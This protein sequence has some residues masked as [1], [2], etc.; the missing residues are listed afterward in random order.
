MIRFVAPLAAFFTLVVAAGC[1]RSGEFDAL[2]ALDNRFDILISGGQ[3]ADG[4]GAAAVRADVLVR[5]DT[6]AY[7]GPVDE[8]RV[9]VATSIDA[10]GRIV[11]PGFID[12]HAHGNPIRDP[13]LR[14]FLAMGVTTITLGQDGSS[15]R[16][17]DLGAWM[18]S[19]DA[20]GPATNVA[21]FAGHGTIRRLAGVGNE[22]SPTDAQVDSMAALLRRQFEAGAFG[23]S[24]GLEY[25][26]G[27]Y[28]DDRELIPLASVAGEAGR[29]VMSH[30]RSEDDDKVEDAIRELLRQGSEAPVHVSHLK[31]VF[32]RGA[33]RAREILALL[34]SARIA[35]IDVTA[36]V[37]PY[38]ASYTGIGIVFPLW[39]RGDAGFD[40]VVRTRRE[41]LEQ[42]LRERVT[43]RNGPGATLIGSGPFAGR[44]LAE[45]ADEL[46]KP[47]EDVLI[48][49]IGPD[50]A[51][52]AYFVMDEDLQET[53]VADPHVMISS[54]GS[55]TGFHPRGHGTFAKVIAEYV[56]EKGILTLEEAIRKMTSLPASVIRIGDRGRIGP[57]YKAD[58]IVFHPD[59]VHAPAT[60]AEPHQ[61]SRGFEHVIVNGVPAVEAGVFGPRRAGRMLRRYDE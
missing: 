5:G 25:T 21:V 13:G 19:V 32:G 38:T 2:I 27:A 8:S 1:A 14:N 36:D 22:P 48:D 45:V 46:E 26:P 44:T 4:S 49:D 18:D 52:G 23:L 56:R 16:V 17:A 54:D 47:F 55:A 37:Y 40:E 33:Q 41:E 9:E 42:Y 58:V 7:V 6:I 61:L 35:G 43:L 30:M 34:D 28:A 24:T 11:A 53:L 57:G 59:S 39:A 29:V 12:P 20:T 3:V 10:T 15:P 60:Y 31:V 50:G 51:S